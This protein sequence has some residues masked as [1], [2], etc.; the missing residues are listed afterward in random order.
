MWSTKLHLEGPSKLYLPYRSSIIH[1]KCHLS[2]LIGHWCQLRHS[3]V[4]ISNKYFHVFSHAASKEFAPHFREAASLPS[5][6]LCWQLS[7]AKVPTTI[8]RQWGCCQA[9]HAVIRIAHPV[10]HHSHLL[11]SWLL[12]VSLSGLCPFVFSTDLVQSQTKWG[13]CPWLLSTVVVV[14]CENR[15]V[16][17]LMSLVI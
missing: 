8:S 4:N 5:I 16:T 14:A 12:F 11:P 10:S 17:S 15:N 9:E 7:L 3:V 2:D 13:P 1:R 6:R